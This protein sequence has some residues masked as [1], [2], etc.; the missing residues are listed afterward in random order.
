MDDKEDLEKVQLLWSNNPV[1]LQYYQVL[2]E[3]YL[4][5]GHAREPSVSYVFGGLDFIPVQTLDNY[6]GP[7]LFMDSFL[8]PLDKGP[9]LLAAK[10]SSLHF[11]TWS[12]TSGSLVLN[13]N[14][15]SV[16]TKYVRIVSAKFIRPAS[17]QVFVTLVQTDNSS[18][19]V[20]KVYA[21]TLEKK[22]IAVSQVKET[23]SQLAKCLGEVRKRL[24][25]DE[26]ILPVL[27]E[28]KKTVLTTDG[29]NIF[30]GTI[31]V[32]D[33][34]K[35][36]ESVSNIEEIKIVPKG[37][38]HQDHLTPPSVALASILEESRN[39]IRD[40]LNELSNVLMSNK[41]G[42]ISGDYNFLNHVE[43][44]EI[45][46]LNTNLEL[47]VLNN[48]DLEDILEYALKKNTDQPQRITGEWAFNKLSGQE[49]VLP[50]KIA[51]VE[52]D[53]FLLKICPSRNV[54]EEAQEV[55]QLT[56]FKQDVSIPDGIIMPAD[57]TVNGI[58]IS[59]L[60]LKNSPIKEIKGFKHAANL[61]GENGFTF[62]FIN[63]VR[64]GIFNTNK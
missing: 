56:V 15:S 2:E 9:L 3:H 28:E 27:E 36:N 10:S 53:N 39:L 33:S 31:Y 57:A 43:I 13:S 24:D 52:V 60:V 59:D 34:I 1:S 63:D 46:A 5:I 6:F 32:M 41:P 22:E 20:L 42:V 7:T 14:S 17:S 64:T 35:F 54:E 38:Y 11:Y 18:R 62:S 49:V 21:V 12:T 26:K 40:V 23:E 29:D 58:I 25:E 50:S 61:I 37:F 16:P 8:L 4:L 44:K 55:S 51:D 30:A 19:S 48:V 47:K 45:R